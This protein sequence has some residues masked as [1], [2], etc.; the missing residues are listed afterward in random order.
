M[1]AFNDQ[2]NF[3]FEFERGLKARAYKTILIIPDDCST[4]CL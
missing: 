2:N 4:S 3:W 1:P